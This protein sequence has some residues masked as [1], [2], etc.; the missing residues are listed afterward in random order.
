MSTPDYEYVSRLVETPYGR[1]HV[2]G[3][4]AL[5]YQ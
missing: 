3:M 2:R 4:E 5:A 1:L